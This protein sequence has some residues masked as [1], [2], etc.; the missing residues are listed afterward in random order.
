MYRPLAG[1]GKAV[2]KVLGRGPGPAGFRA[3]GGAEDVLI[4][5]AFAF[6]PGLDEGDKLGA[7]YAVS[8]LE[9]MRGQLV[10]GGLL[11]LECRGGEE[12]QFMLCQLHGTTSST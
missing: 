7:G 2:A 3:R 4:L 9:A 8:E 11:F 6:R 5:P 1:F 10:T 12:F